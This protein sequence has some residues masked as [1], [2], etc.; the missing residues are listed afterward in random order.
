MEKSRPDFVHR[1][2][3]AAP[4]RDTARA[5]TLLLLHGT[6]GDENDL[7]E[8][9]RLLTPGG[10]I[11]SPRG[12]VL[13]NGMPRFFR[14]LAEGVFDIDDLKRRTYELADFIEEAAGTYAFDLKR[15]IA[16]GFSNGANIAGSLL[17]LR[18]G[19]LAGAALLHPMVPFVPE[20]APDLAGTP[21][22]IGAGRGDPIA[23]PPEAERLA[24]LFES[25]HARVTL[26]WLPGGHSISHE[27]VR[28]VQQWLR[29]QGV[30]N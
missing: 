28:S 27:E 21:V 23:P 17:L 15:V 20:V 16:I 26:Q 19:L 6:G 3:P 10:A 24:A 9:G 30:T 8:L 1:Y 11:L 25:A 5:Y 18:P 2:L 4:G 7:L 12:K 29:Q 14:R 13:E 22:F